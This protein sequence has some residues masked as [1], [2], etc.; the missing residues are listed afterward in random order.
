ML[1]ILAVKGLADRLA[2]LGHDMGRKTSP[3]L[4]LLR[5]ADKRIAVQGRR[6]GRSHV[7][8]R[9][10]VAALHASLHPVVAERHDAPIAAVAVA[11]K[12]ALPVVLWEPDL[13]TYVGVLLGLHRGDDAAEGRHGLSGQLVAGCIVAARNRLRAYDRRIWKLEACEVFARGCKRRR[14]T[15]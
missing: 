3:V 9:G 4:P 14:R 1:R 2:G 6:R 12:D 13:D 10:G 8:R 7:R 5:M 11:V 15:R